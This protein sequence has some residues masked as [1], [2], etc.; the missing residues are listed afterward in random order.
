[1]RVGISNVAWNRTEDEEILG[2]LPQLGVE[3]LEVAPT[4]LWDD[5]LAAPP[6]VVRDYRERAGL[7]VVSLQ[8]LLHGHP[9]LTVF[10]NGSAF[11][12]LQRM[13]DLAEGLGAQ[14]LVFGSPGNRRREPLTQS[15][16]FELAVPFFAALGRYAAER[17]VCVCIEPLP[18][19]LGTDFVNTAAEAGELVRAVGSPGFGIHLDS[20]VLHLT[21]E[22]IASPPRHFHATEVGFGVPGSGGVD[23]ARYAAQLRDAGYDGV[24]SVELLAVDGSNRDRVLASV[25]HALHVYG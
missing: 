2:L 16:A 6:A 5:P 9:E 24:V 23:H 20:L 17:G 8:S 15:E 12:H 25:D 13:C 11:D 7:P 10:P 3:A 1:M 18:A 22:E 21:G 19:E 14:T 4:K